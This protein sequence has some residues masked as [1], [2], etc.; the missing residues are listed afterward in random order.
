MSCAEKYPVAQE[1]WGKWSMHR[2][3]VRGSFFVKEPNLRYP[4]GTMCVPSPSDRIYAC[5]RQFTMNCLRACA[6]TY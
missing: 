4:G 3:S 2:Q 1:K 6:C 5:A